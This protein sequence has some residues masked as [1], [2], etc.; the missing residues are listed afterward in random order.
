[1]S[2]VTCYLE[3]SKVREII[4]GVADE[5]VHVTEGIL[6]DIDQ[7]PIITVDEDGQRAA[8]QDICAW[9]ERVRCGLPESLYFKA[10]RALGDN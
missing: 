8:L 6:A 4:T 3:R 9:Y 10:K 1:M 7:L 5:Q 2:D